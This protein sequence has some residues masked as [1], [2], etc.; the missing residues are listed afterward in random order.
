MKKLFFLIITAAG[1][2]AI[3]SCDDSIEPFADY[4]QKYV[5]NCILNGDSSF[6]VATLTSDYKGTT[7][8]P[9]SNTTDPSIE[10]AL[11]RVWW[12]DSVAIFKD[13]SIARF[14]SSH[15]TTPYKFYYAKN[16][17]PRARISYQ[18]EAQL[19]NGKKL[20]S[21]LSPPSGI[22]FIYVISDSAMPIQGQDGININW[23]NYHDYTVY[24]SHVVI[25]YYL[26]G[27]G[28]KRYEKYV[29]QSYTEY[30]GKYLPI[31]PK[32]DILTD[33]SVDYKT[34]DRAM[35]EIS[36]DDPDKSKYQI[37]SAAVELAA[38]LASMTDSGISLGSRKGPT[39]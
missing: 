1:I 21:T 22:D 6:Q 23:I 5:L 7:L 10:G 12:Q 33:C 3:Y 24:I 9:Y 13:S 29:P 32:P 20:R 37:I 26:S 34:I 11:I 16:F 35:A 36:G 31:E 19:P 39:A 18:I 15:Y 28:N 17:I 30:D 2:L 4:K 38:P 14:D 27:T 25:Y 8:D